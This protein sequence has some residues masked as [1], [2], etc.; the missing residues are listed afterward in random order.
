MMRFGL[1]G[2]V[3]PPACDRDNLAVSISSTRKVKRGQGKG[4]LSRSLSGLTVYTGTIDLLGI[5]YC[6]IVIHF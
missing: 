6:D 4:C 3:N 5:L 1:A 2:Q